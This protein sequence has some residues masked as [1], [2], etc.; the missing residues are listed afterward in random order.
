MDR[1][2]EITLHLQGIFRLQVDGREVARLRTRKTE[3]LLAWLAFYRGQSFSRDALIARFWPADDEATGRRKLRLALH[4]IRNEIGDGMEA[5]R[6]TLVIPSIWVDA[7]DDDADGEILPEFEVD[8]LEALRIDFALLRDAR[9]RNRL[10]EHSQKGEVAGS[11]ATLYKLIESDPSDPRWYLRLHKELLGQGRKREARSLAGLA[12]AQL[13]EECPPELAALGESLVP[14]RSFIGRTHLFAS[15]AESLLGDDE[16]VVTILLG[17]GGIGKT[18]LAQELVSVARAES[19]ETRFV[20]L[21]GLTTRRDVVRVVEDALREK[22]QFDPPSLPPTLLVLDNAEA[23]EPG[24]LEWISRLV[25]GTSLRVLITSQRTLPPLEAIPFEVPP[26]AVPASGDLDAVMRSEAAQL[27][28]RD[29]ELEL[30]PENAPKISAICRKMGG[31]P[32]AIRHAAARLNV[33]SLD[34][35]VESLASMRPVRSDDPRHR[36]V[37]ACVGW[38]LS[39][40]S[41]H[42]VADLR[43]LAQFEDGFQSETAAMM[44]I[45]LEELVQMNWIVKRLGDETH[46]IL[47]PF[48]EVLRRDS[49]DDEAAASRI[50]ID[51]VLAQRVNEEIYQRYTTFVEAMTVHQRDLQ[52][53]YA[54]ALEREDFDCAERLLVG[55][56]HVKLRQGSLA[57]VS[58]DVA[59]FFAAVPQ[60]RWRDF[61][62]AIN[63]RG[64]VAY[65]KNRWDEAEIYYQMLAED[66]EVRHRIVGWANLALIAVN[67]RQYSRARELTLRTLAAPDIPIRNLLG[68]RLN[69]SETEMALGRYEEAREISLA[70][71]SR[72]DDHS[73][74]EVYRGLFLLRLAQI[75][76]LDGKDDDALS[77]A[78]R[79]R[80]LF[81]ALGEKLRLEEACVVLVFLAKRQ[82]DATLLRET[83]KVLLDLPASRSALEWAVTLSEPTAEALSSVDWSI[84]PVWMERLYPQHAQLEPRS[85][86]I[87][88]SD[89]EWR[90]RAENRMKRL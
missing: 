9:L 50:T 46:E 57:W 19:V 52:R 45:D 12:N 81:T 71:L 5:R 75:D 48:R 11:I 32:L 49:T 53:G 66:R 76:I 87:K 59:E 4:S 82:N 17:P 7:L 25:V 15:L 64:S 38:S 29:T 58:E 63:R 89:V 62:E 40:G 88:R 41:P 37:A 24:A 74:Y 51:N 35:L 1:P 3:A 22:E 65:F 67:R 21:L 72:L 26:L 73:E 31:V 33:T 84:V 14:R 2:H 61:P 43:R 34:R 47:P 80:D 83:L 28:I 86:V 23:I 79:A 44:G 30:T 13:E 27:F 16:P 56:Y 69:L 78:V 90:I 39:L 77:W 42:Q 20:R 70:E 55:L 54:A 36:S 60:D 68:R 18:R 10:A 6:D 8:G 85:P